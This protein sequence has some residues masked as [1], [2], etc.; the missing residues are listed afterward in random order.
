MSRHFGRD[1][2]PLAWAALTIGTILVLAI[3]LAA[4]A[5]QVEVGAGIAHASTQG[6]GTWYQDGFQHTLQLTQPVVEIGLTGRLTRHM[7]WHVDA[8][9]LGR[10]SSDSWDTTDANYNGSDGCVETCLPLQHFQ[11]SGRVYGVQALLSRHTTGPWRFGLEGGPFLYHETWR[12]NVPNWYPTALP[13]SVPAWFTSRTPSAGW[14]IGQTIPVA[15]SGSRWALGAVV[16]A[17]LAHGRWTLAL[18]YYA[19]GAG[20]PGHVGPWPP[21]WNGQTVVMISRVFG[22]GQ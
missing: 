6:N 16:G 4:H 12:L 8:V 7:D 20:F 14:I 5:A 13:G 10:Y 19:D 2:S 21:L 22:G 15:T 1:G 9:S 17:T 3:R 11:G 18:R